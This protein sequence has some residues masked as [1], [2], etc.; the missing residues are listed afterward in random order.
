MRDCADV[1]LEAHFAAVPDELC[2]PLLDDNLS[3]SCWSDADDCSSVA[4]LVDLELPDWPPGGELQVAPPWWLPDDAY[5]CEY[6]DGASLAPDSLE[7]QD[8]EM[9]DELGDIET[10]L[11]EEVVIETKRRQNTLAAR[12][13]RKKKSEY[14]QELEATVERDREEQERR[15]PSQLRDRAVSLSTASHPASFSTTPWQT[16]TITNM[17]IRSVRDAEIIL[18]AVAIGLLPMV[19]HRLTDEERSAVRPGCVYVWEERSSDLFE[20]SGQEIRRF[21]EGRSWGPS[22]AR[23]NFLIYYE[24]D[25]PSRLSMSHKKNVTSAPPLIKQTYS[26]FVDYPKNSRKWQL[27]AYYTPDS[28]E[29]LR[30]TDDVPTLARIEPPCNTYVCTRSKS[31]RRTTGHIVASEYT[32]PSTVHHD[33]DVAFTP[34]TSSSTGNDWPL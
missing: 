32:L 22:R 3:L 18:H 4:S 16:P 14:R 28:L 12:R 10:A 24:K 23:D 33:R 15:M 8:V 27:I 19:V 34:S 30:T 2:F 5:K 20:A 11:A 17:R 7:D 9:G 13:S 1:G 25:S 29:S 6:R 21:T 26:V 31:A